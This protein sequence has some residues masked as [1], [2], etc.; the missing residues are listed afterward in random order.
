MNIYL[1]V[2]KSW[3]IDWESQENV[4]VF[5]SEEEA[6]QYINSEEQKKITPGV[7]GGR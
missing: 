1:V 7:K 2:E 4:G 6:Q 5:K 3:G